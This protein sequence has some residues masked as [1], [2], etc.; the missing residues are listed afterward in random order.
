ME[1]SCEHGNADNNYFAI[2]NSIKALKNEDN[3][4]ILNFIKI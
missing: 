3:H 1:T 4:D 2:D